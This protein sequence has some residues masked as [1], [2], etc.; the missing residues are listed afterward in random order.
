MR[1][2]PGYPRRAVLLL[3]AV[4]FALLAVVAA[5]SGLVGGYVTQQ[6][7]QTADQHARSGVN[8]LV[9][10]GPRLPSLSAR[11][12][13]RGLSPTD[14]AELG[15]AV[16]SGRRAGLISNLVLW[17]ASGRVVY[18]S[19]GGAEARISS[20]ALD[21]RAALAGSNTVRSHPGE[22]D[23]SR[24]GGRGVLDA[25]EPLRDAHG[26]VF[27]VLEVSLPLQPIEADAARLQSRIYLVL[28]GAALVLWLMALPFAA[29][30]AREV[31]LSWVPGRGRVR[32]AVR[33][34]LAHD[35]IVLVYQPQ[36]SPADGRCHAVEALVRMC[37][38]GQLRSPDAF[39]PHIEGTSLDAQLTDRVVELALAQLA[40]WR[41]DGYTVRMSVNL[42]T[43]NLA[44]PG[45]PNRLA[46]AIHRHGCDARDLTLEV[47]ETGVLQD[48]AV[49]GPVIEELSALGVDLAIDD[50]G[51]GNSS[52]ARLHR[53]PVR[54]V[55][56]DRSFVMRPDPRSRAYVAAIVGF[57]QRL[58]LR[59]VA[60]GVEDMDA[61]TYLR[62]LDCDLV[63]GYF[64]SRPIPPA[65]MTY[66]FAEHAALP[67]PQVA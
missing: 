32:R 66:W 53:L 23:Q 16:V 17:T 35:Q 33:R 10:V 6:A 15:A 26:H 21:V 40:R 30:A 55:K 47:T 5:V 39:L 22:V 36:V 41:T 57:A 56:I 67:V 48:F 4:S 38:A 31:V 20:P 64:V 8:L 50:F 51:T 9:G 18:A 44:D 34:A 27:G 49:T 54:E 61:L 12:L 11:S 37:D 1:V 46:A 45:L 59:V 19:D 25:F 29:R 13:A 52:I 63:Q 3:L 43:A 65:E 62:D 58:G 24:Y 60:E 7:R 14:G 42:S 2:F 28:F